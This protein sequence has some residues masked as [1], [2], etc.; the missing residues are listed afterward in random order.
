MSV[1]LFYGLQ[2]ST[3]ALFASQKAISLTGNNIANADT[4]G[5]TR[6]R[7]ISASIDP[8]TDITRFN[9]AL[10]ATVGGGVEISYIDQVRNAYIDTQYRMENAALGQWQTRSEEMSY[11]ETLLDETE[12]GTISDAVSEFFDSIQELSMDTV[13]TEIRT[14][15]QQTAITMIDTL[16]TY[17]DELTGLQSRMNDNMSVTVDE[18]NELV[19]GIV[20]YNKQISAYELS[21]EQANDLR[22][23][24]N[25][26]LDSLSELVNIEYHEDSD[27]HLS[28][29]VEG[30]LLLDH[31]DARV[32]EVVA[33]QTG[34]V[35]G[36]T[37]FYS[38]NFADNGATFDYSNGKLEGYRMLR[39]GNAVD[40][41]GIPRILSNLNALAQSIAEEFN[42]V[43]ETGYT[44]AT[45]STA[46]V[47]GVDFFEIPAGGYGDINAGNLSL[48]AEVLSSVNN[49]AASD[50]L[51]DL[52]A[53]NTQ[54]GNNVIAL[55]LAELTSSST[56]SS[57]G[58]FEDFLK[59]SIVEVA[60]ESAHDNAMYESQQS[61]VDNL[62]QRRESVSGVST[63]EEMVNLITYQHAYSAASRMI[64]AIDE[65]LEVLI[66]RTGK[67]GL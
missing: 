40:E 36:T 61:I 10:S 23:K 22:D 27:N 56:L 4:K 54:E 43:H 15:V 42:T 55:Q 12:G 18:I 14:N 13:S 65:A 28:V 50:T 47:T 37:G 17:Y 59:S 46:S 7:V 5:Y 41:V 19:R 62:L 16:A 26:M 3:S 38:I 21:G 35:S 31:T 24:R 44:M 8:S 52:S 29:T 51:I 64:T 57:I 9:Q 66:N 49:I 1:S 20:D 39:D 63:D 34:V 11:I 25:V 53:D 33:D 67:V 2:I 32:L 30:E 60:I 48:S 58:S 45:A 6:Q